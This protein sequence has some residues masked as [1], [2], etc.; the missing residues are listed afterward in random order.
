MEGVPKEQ[1]WGRV[2]KE[3][4]S[5]VENTFFRYKQI[6]GCKLH[7]RHTKVQ[8]VEAALACRILNRMGKVRMPRSVAVSA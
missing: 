6:L 2:G 4:Q 8:Q 5:R 3:R 7:V 1:F